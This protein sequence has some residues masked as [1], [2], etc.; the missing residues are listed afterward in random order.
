MYGLV[1]KAVKD[2]VVSNFGK[3][4]WD[5][6]AEKAGIP[7]E[8]FIPLRTYDDSIT[9]SLV[10]AA[11]QVLGLSGDDILKAFGKYWIIF[12]AHEGYGEL[13][14]LFGQNFDDCLMNLNQMHNRMGAM[15]PDLK[16]PRFSVE[17]T[18]DGDIRLEYHSSRAGLA[19][20]VYGLI[21]GLSVKHNTKVSISYINRVTQ[22]EPDIFT[23]KKVA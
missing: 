7:L 16:P 12:T 13:M 22:N 5:L 9:Y 21:E 2:L 18:T 3:D 8:E 19:P 1:N 20:M 23:I 11:S 10:G 17:N 4:K 6:I 15:M 14:N